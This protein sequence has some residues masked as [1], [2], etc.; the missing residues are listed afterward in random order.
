MCWNTKNGV[1]PIGYTGMNYVS[2][3]SGNKALIILPGLSDGIEY[4]EG[5]STP[6]FFA[7]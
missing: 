5:Q 7:I 1:V 3:G 4:G 2:F 6:S